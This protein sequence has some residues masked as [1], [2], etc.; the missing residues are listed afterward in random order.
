MQLVGCLDLELKLLMVSFSLI[1]VLVSWDVTRAKIVLNLA[2][3]N[4]LKK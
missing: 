1:S 4:K 3:I 2:R